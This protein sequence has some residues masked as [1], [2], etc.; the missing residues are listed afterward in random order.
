MLADRL[1]E[2]PDAGQMRAE[3]ITDDDEAER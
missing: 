2:L 1:E 3:R